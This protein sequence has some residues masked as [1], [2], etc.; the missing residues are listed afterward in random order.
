MGFFDKFFSSEAKKNRKSHI[1]N[2][3]SV[4]IADGH[5]AS[6]EVTFVRAVADRYGLTDKEFNELTSGKNVPFHKPESK[7]EQFSQLW[8]MFL[9]MIVDNDRDPREIAIL[10]QVAV[11]FGISSIIVDDMNSVFN[12]KQLAGFVDSPAV[13]TRVDFHMQMLQYKYGLTTKQPSVILPG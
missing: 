7:E 10:K 2:L 12:D 11:K 9:V 6:A 4:A 8:E 5:L 1:Y 3:L 13:Q